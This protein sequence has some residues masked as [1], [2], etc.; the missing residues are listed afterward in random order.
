M[1]EMSVAHPP[2]LMA[3]ARA[4]IG[5]L[6]GP[7]RLVVFSVFLGLIGAALW[8]LPLRDVQRITTHGRD[9]L[10]GRARASAT[11][12]A[13]S[14]SRCACIA[15]C[16]RSRSPRSLW[17]WGS[18][19]STRTSCWRCY[20]VGVLLA[21][22]T[23]QR[24]IR[25]VKDF[26]NAMLDVVY[27]G[28]AV[29]VFNAVGPVPLGP[30][31]VA[32]HRRLRRRHDRRRL[33]RLPDR[34]E[35]RHHDR[36]GT[37]RAR[38][39]RA[40]V[41][42]SRSPPRTTNASLGIVAADD[43]HHARRWLAF[44]LVP[45]VLLVLAGRSPRAKV[46]VAPIAT[47]SCTGP[48]RS[49]TR[50][51]RS[52]S[53]P[54]SCSTASPRCSASSAPSS[55]SS[56]RCAARRCGSTRSG[57]DEHAARP[58][59]R[60][61]LR[62]AGGAQR[63]ALRARSSPVRW[64]AI[65]RSA[66]RS[67]NARAL[68]E[69]W[70]CCAGARVRRACS[71]SSTRRV[72]AKLGAH[73][74]SLLSTVAGL[75]SVALENG[76]L[77]EAIRAMS[78]EK[79]ELARRAFYDPLTQIANRSLFIETVATSLSRSSQPRAARRGH[80]HRPRRV[81]GDQRQLR[82]RGRRPGAQ[83]GRCATAASRCASSTWPRASV[84][85][86]SACSSTACAISAMRRSWPTASSRRCDGRSRIGDAMVTIGA[87]VGVAVVED[88]CGRARA[89]GADAPRR[90]GD[91][92]RQ[93]P[94][95]EPLRGL[96]R[97]RARA[98]DRPAGPTS[99][100][101]LL[102]APTVVHLRWVGDTTALPVDRNLRFRRRRRDPGRPQG[103]RRGGVPRDDSD[104]RVSPRRTPPAVRAVHRLPRGSSPRSSRPS[105]ATSA[106]MPPRRVRCCR[107]SRYR[108]GRLPRAPPDSRS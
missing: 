65:S 29:L 94:G 43:P 49:C 97:G 9:S 64:R 21:S 63:A 2:V 84:A 31:R 40:R 12:R 10:V 26:A 45:P 59:V 98:G 56:R 106:S 92:P 96:R 34:A 61:D 22:W 39:G 107:P 16:R 23:R 48:P 74:Q 99:A 47:S 41:P 87:S 67:R 58:H 5:R 33:V 103:V 75:I 89:R 8:L 76:Q 44:A 108:G 80:V 7:Q 54:A 14:S 46:S 51:V 88:R 38:R 68:P 72:A 30:A 85:T 37:A 86:S 28:V 18:S 20:V 25:W 52:A 11:R 17:R 42:A 50:P 95:Q 24:R 104:R 6:N 90:H 70:W 32:Q 81:Q 35:R 77:A 79:A 62:R 4:R 15:R 57:D 36:A 78:V 71:C 105:T 60:S 93:A 91:V 69:R 13:C 1:S 102:G 53:A 101:R 27:I 55:W 19:S 73:E 82:S 66:S 100:G 83:R 3:R